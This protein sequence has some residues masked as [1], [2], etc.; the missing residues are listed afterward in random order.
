MKLLQDMV[1]V[2]AHVERKN[3]DTVVTPTPGD[4]VAQNPSLGLLVSVSL[5]VSAL[6]HWIAPLLLQGLEERLPTSPGLKSYK[7]CHSTK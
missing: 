4:S 5:S 1:D 3:E 6:A 7:P 2:S